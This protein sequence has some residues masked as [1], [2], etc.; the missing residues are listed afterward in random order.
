M[1]AGK[2]ANM[3]SALEQKI[4]AK[5]D[6][7]TL[8]QVLNEAKLAPKAEPKTAK[9]KYSSYAPFAK[10]D[11]PTATQFQN[12]YP[13]YLFKGKAPG[14]YGNIGDNPFMSV[15]GANDPM[16]QQGQQQK[17]AKLMEEEDKIK[18]LFAMIAQSKQGQQ[19]P[20]QG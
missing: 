17:Q 9:E 13:E 20:V 6:L 7:K 18:K 8:E 19:P 1:G 3:K 10:S 5:K 14:D 12:P 11:M 15:T 4:A 2:N 16:I